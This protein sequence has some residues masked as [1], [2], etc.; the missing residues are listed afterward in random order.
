[1]N[2]HAKPSS[3]N[4]TADGR[5]LPGNNE[6]PYGPPSIVWSPDMDQVIHDNWENPN[7]SR[8]E[9]ADKIGVALNT[10]QRRAKKLGY[11]RKPGRPAKPIPYDRPQY[12]KEMQF[13][14]LLAEGKSLEKIASIMGYNSRKSA[15]ATL[16]K[17]R[18]KLGWQA[19]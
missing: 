13:A 5:F 19:V 4:R 17:I 7:I 9:I 3:K 14:Q 18:T 6:N 16:N 10:A 1:M 15:S 11:S 12:P 2:I 8:Q